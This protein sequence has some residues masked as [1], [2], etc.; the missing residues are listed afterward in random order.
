[1]EV[2]IEILQLQQAWPHRALVTKPIIPER[3]RVEIPDIDIIQS[4]DTRHR[5]YPEWRYQ[6]SILSRV[7]IPDIDTI[8]IGQ[9]I[10]SRLS[11]KYNCQWLS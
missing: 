9:E 1:L 8:Q 4:G 2:R 7:E 11:V 3:H 6:I 5:Y 10:P